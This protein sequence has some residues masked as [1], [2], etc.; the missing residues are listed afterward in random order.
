MRL[1]AF[2]F[3]GVWM[4]DFEFTA[5]RGECPTPVCMVASELGSGKTIKLFQ[6]ELQKLTTSPYPTS[7]DTLFVA[8]FASAEL[9]CHLALRWPLPTNVLDL[10]VEFRNLTNGLS[11]PAGAGVLGALVYFGLDA[12]NGIEKETMRQL[13]MRGG[14]YT[15]DEKRALLTYCESDVI[16]LRKLFGAMLPQIDLPRALLRGRY[17]KAVGHMEKNGVPIDTHSLRILKEN[18]DGI[19]DELI[20]RVDTNYGVYDGRTFKANQ[21]AQWL[22]VNHIPWPQLESG[23]LAL[24]DDTFRSMEKLH[25]LIAPLRQLRVT[26]S[27]MRLSELAVGADC[28]NR[29]LLSPFRAR[30]SRNQPSNTGFIFGPAVWLRSLIKP[31]PGT[32]LVYIDWSQQEFGIAAALS[33]DVAM[34]NAYTSGDPYLAFAKQAGAAPPDATKA[35]HAHVRNQFKECALAV[36]YGMEAESLARRIGQRVIQAR[37]LL[38]LHHETYREFWKWSDAALDCA[39]LQ[40]VLPTVY[41]WNIHVGADTNPRM[42]RNFPMQANGAEMLRLACC[43][44]TESGIRI[45]APV[46]DAVL[47]E[48]PLGQLDEAIIETQNAM[49][50]ASEVVL[51]GFRLRSDAKVIRYPDRYEDE[52]GKEMWETVWQVINEMPPETC[53]LAHMVGVH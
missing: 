38:R 26:L 30:T 45:C 25:P 52:R 20:Q 37:E 36:Q 50:K 16:A 11:T 44:A 35:S 27:Q 43:L 5:P 7:S 29:T 10:Y 17:M 8:Y 21:F 42:I 9:G 49:A 23:A 1:G 18:W 33:R 24:D 28:R 12:M 19:Q 39:M 15:E 2:E 13:A 3:S 51:G 22:L 46:H 4:V 48:A 41:G 47:I 53:A 6:H 40:G 32:A 14:P 31:E 34:Q